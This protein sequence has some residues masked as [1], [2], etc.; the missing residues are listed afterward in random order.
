M[1]A[2]R[3]LFDLT[4]QLFPEFAVIAEQWAIRENLT[5][6]LS[7]MT[8]LKLSEADLRDVS[9]FMATVLNIMVQALQ[10]QVQT[11]RIVER[12]GAQEAGDIV[13]KGAWVLLTLGAWL[14][15]EQRIHYTGPPPATPS[16]GRGEAAQ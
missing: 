3:T 8:T 12:I 7:P 13:G 4:R 5:G 16:D 15:Q 11:G 2:P 10:G 9:Q 1:K 6:K 14:A